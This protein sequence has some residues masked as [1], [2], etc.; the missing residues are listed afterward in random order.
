MTDTMTAA[1]YN[2]YLETGELPVQQSEVDPPNEKVFQAIAERLFRSHDWLVFHTYDARRSEPGFPDLVCVHPK[3]GV[4]FAELKMPDGRLS[5][6]QK[7]WLTA[8]D[9]AG[10]RPYV[11][12]PNNYRDME[13]VA[14]G[15]ATA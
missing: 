1:E 2:R 3:H 8:L 9:R 10:A 7:R 15:E 4:V 13:A 6:A 11:W 14:R 12:R 5:D